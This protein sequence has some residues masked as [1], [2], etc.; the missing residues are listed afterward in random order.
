MH[1]AGLSEKG[2]E[3]NRENG[4]TTETIDLYWHGAKRRKRVLRREQL[5]WRLMDAKAK[6]IHYR[7]FDVLDSID[8][9]PVDGVRNGKCEVC[10]VAVYDLLRCS[11]F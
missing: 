5:V 3:E 6:Y 2:T 9:P 11:T 7:V 8:L 4:A 10:G 1:C